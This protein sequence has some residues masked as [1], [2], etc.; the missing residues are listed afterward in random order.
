M[1][2]IA[3]KMIALLE[4]VSRYKTKDHKEDESGLPPKNGKAFKSK[5]LAAVKW[6]LAV[7]I[8]SEKRMK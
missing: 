7:R 6:V 8:R 5:L 2:Q 3:V 1:W 4:R